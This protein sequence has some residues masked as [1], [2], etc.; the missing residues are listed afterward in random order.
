MI[1]AGSGHRPESSTKW[2]IPQ[3]RDNNGCNDL[4]ILKKKEKKTFQKDNKC[5]AEHRIAESGKNNK[6]HSHAAKS[7]E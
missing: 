5:R 4:V 3:Q 6:K 7:K 2:A 1:S